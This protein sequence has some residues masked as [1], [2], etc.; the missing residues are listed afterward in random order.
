MDYLLCILVVLI[1]L[2][3]EVRTHHERKR[4][5]S[6]PLEELALARRDCRLDSGLVVGA[7]ACFRQVGC[8]GKESVGDNEARQNDEEPSHPQVSE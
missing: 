6:I 4:D 8:V 1:W 2:E 5:R 7:E 3:C